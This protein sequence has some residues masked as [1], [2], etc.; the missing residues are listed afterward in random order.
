ME[1]R[2]EI[3]QV[4]QTYV[5]SRSDLTLS[6]GTI[7]ERFSNTVGKSYMSFGCYKCDSIFGDWFVME[8]KLESLYESLEI[9]CEEEIELKEMI[10]MPIEHWCFPKNGQFCT[11]H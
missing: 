1:Y 5:G 3:I 4:A 2:P 6:L 8:A 7:K 9:I 10:E 11:E